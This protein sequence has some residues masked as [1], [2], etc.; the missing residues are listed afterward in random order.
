MCVCVSLCSRSGGGGSHGVILGSSVT[1]HL[2]AEGGGQMKTAME[3]N[4][5]RIIEVQEC[6]ELKSTFVD[7]T[8]SIQYSFVLGC[9]TRLH[10]QIHRHHN[11]EYL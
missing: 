8:L 5:K 7:K 6:K 1:A 2:C 11:P 3:K 9:N 10:H 4:K